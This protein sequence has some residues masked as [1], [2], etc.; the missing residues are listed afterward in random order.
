MTFRTN[1]LTYVVYFLMVVLVAS[2]HWM[3]GLAVYDYTEFFLG[4]VFRAYGSLEE[5]VRDV[6]GYF[7]S[8]ERLLERVRT[9]E[10]DNRRLRRRLYRA[11]SARRSREALRRYLRLPP[12]PSGEL[13]PAEVL[14]VNLTGWERTLRLNR[15]RAGGARSGQPVLALSGDSWV[16]R[17]EILSVSDQGSVVLL[18]SDP[19]FRVGVRIQGVPDRQ[20]VARGWGERGLRVDHFPEVISVEPGARVVAANVSTVAPGGL[21]VGTV[22]GPVES[23]PSRVGR[24]LRIAPPPITGSAGPVWLLVTDE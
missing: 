15:G 14:A 2:T 6:T 10:R 19:R 3:P 24:R 5:S 20:F 21:T 9:L 8:R 18:A 13:L 16:L 7:T 22:R 23:R 1:V 12:A 11:R 17:G 4:G